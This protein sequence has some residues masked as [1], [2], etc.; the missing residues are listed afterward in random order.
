MHP[1]SFALPALVVFGLFFLLP[2]LLNVVYSFTDWNTFTSRIRFIGM[3]NYVQMFRED[4]FLG[5]FVNALAFT[6]VVVVLQNL[7]GF[8]LALALH[9]QRP[10]NQV[11]RAVFFVPCVVSIVVWGYLF[12]TILDMRG[13][14]NGFLAV[15]SG[16]PVRIAWLGS[17]RFT[18]LVVAAVSTWIWAGFTMM[19]F[20]TSINAIPAEILESARMD[21]AGYLRT[22]GNIIVPIIVPGLTVNL[23]LTIIGGLKVFDIIMVLTRGGPWPAPPRSSTP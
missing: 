12:E 18:I 1:I 8:G 4:R 16:H 11:L 19:I 20:V 13:L 14:L 2:I 7:I 22:V 21:G 6:A 5:A 9:A 10:I 3:E 15:L 17:V 23:V